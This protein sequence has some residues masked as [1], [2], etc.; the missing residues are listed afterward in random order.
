VTP[1]EF[2]E[3]RVK[4]AQGPDGAYSAAT[5]RRRLTIAHMFGY[6]TEEMGL[7]LRFKRQL[8]APSQ[9]TIRR[10]GRAQQT[11]GRPR[12]IICGICLILH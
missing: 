9:R 7:K 4:L 5:L 8:N 6:G 10:R 1:E 2:A 11:V 3:L 12:N